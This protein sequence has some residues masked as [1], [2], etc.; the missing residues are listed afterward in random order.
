MSNHSTLHRREPLLNRG[1]SIDSISND[2]E[3][4]RP[5]S[6]GF[7]SSLSSITH[8]KLHPLTYLTFYLSA[9]CSFALSF[10]VND[11]VFY[12]ATL[13]PVY[14]CTLIIAILGLH[15]QSPSYLRPALIAHI[16]LACMYVFFIVV[17]D[18]DYAS[19]CISLNDL[20]DRALNNA[21]D[22][23]CE[24]SGGLSLILFNGLTL[25]ALLVELLFVACLVNVT[26]AVT[27]NEL[28]EDLGLAIMSYIVS[29]LACVAVIVMMLL[30]SFSPMG[31]SVE[32]TCPVQNGIVNYQSGNGS[33]N[34]FIFLPSAHTNDLGCC[35]HINSLDVGTCCTQHACRAKPLYSTGLLDGRSEQC[36]DLLGQLS[37]APCLADSGTFAHD[38]YVN[39][40]ICSDFCV[41]V[42]HECAGIPTTSNQTQVAYQWCEAQLDVIVS[43]ENKPGLCFND[44]HVVTPSFI[45]ILLTIMILILR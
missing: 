43:P 7:V 42:A 15:R 13:I 41:R 16:V 33:H 3:R 8:A 12:R 44:A 29:G 10:A 28:I 19:K 4:S 23:D 24:L 20:P 39:M 2:P 45:I 22:Y 30:V 31:H 38:G 5:L 18:A 35:P 36:H 26:N 1:Q 27:D 32:G 9:G 14:A 17:T 25:M 6:P 21:V 37:C 11:T 40:S 34:P